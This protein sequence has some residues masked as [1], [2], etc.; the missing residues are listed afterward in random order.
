MLT[1]PVIDAH[2]HLSDIGMAAAFARARRE[3]PAVTVQRLEAHAARPLRI[4]VDGVA[5]VP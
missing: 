5:V 2:V 3:V 1:E 4:D